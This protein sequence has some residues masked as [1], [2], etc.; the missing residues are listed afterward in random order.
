MI[1]ISHMEY[2]RGGAHTA[3]GVL[4]YCSEGKLSANTGWVCMGS[5]VQGTSGYARGWTDLIGKVSTKLAGI[6]SYYEVGAINVSAGFLRVS[7][8][9]AP[10]AFGSYAR[11]YLFWHVWVY[12]VNLSAYV[13]Q[14]NSGFIWDSGYAYCGTTGW[15]RASSPS[16][17]KS[18]NSSSYYGGAPSFRFVTGHVYE[19]TLFMGCTTEVSVSSGSSTPSIFGSFCNSPT[20]PSSNS[21]SIY[22]LAIV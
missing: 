9:C 16:M 14:G 18:F 12:D 1:P 15:I 5:S 11:V 2:N 21:L 19:F 13:D 17:V 20:A 8:H 7:G 6:H 3:P 10:G 4:K 22:G